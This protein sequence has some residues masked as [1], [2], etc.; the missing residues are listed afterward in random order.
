LIIIII[1]Q[2]AS[3]S[4]ATEKSAEQLSAGKQKQEDRDWG[5]KIDFVSLLPTPI[6]WVKLWEWIHYRR[7]P[8]TATPTLAPSNKS[9]NNWNWRKSKYIL[10]STICASEKL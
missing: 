7:P 9:R 5:A 1:R 10:C 6:A 8:T 2:S 3:E 4:R